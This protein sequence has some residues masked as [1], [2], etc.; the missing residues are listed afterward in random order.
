MFMTVTATAAITMA[1]VI[2]MAPA[3][4]VPVMHPA[5]EGVTGASD[6]MITV[7]H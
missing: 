3:G 2:A 4:Q 7:E 5:R 6:G 1:A